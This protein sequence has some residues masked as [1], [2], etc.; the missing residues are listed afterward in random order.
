MRL[1]PSSPDYVSRVTLAVLAAAAPLSRARAQSDHFAPLVLLLPASTRAAAFGDAYVAGRDNDVIFYNPAQLGIARGVGA[2]VARYRSASTLGSLSASTALGS[3]GVGVGVQMLDYGSWP[4]VYPATAGALTSRGPLV[5]S[6]LAATLG[7]AT[8]FRDTRI[9]VAGKYVE[10]RIAG[11]RGGVL[12]ADIGLARDIGQVTVGF[13][14]QN[15][16][17]AIKTGGHRASLPQRYTFGVGGGGLPVGPFDVAASTSVAVLR[18]GFVTPAGGVEVSYSWLD[19][20]AVAARFGVRRVETNAQSPL[21]LG[22]GA[23]VDRI[24]LDYAYERY[25]GAGVAHRVG[26]R[27]RAQ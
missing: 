6:S 9:G 19:G 23:S 13:A 3:G 17:G 18:N 11:A 5:S 1:P 8:V 24:W 16:G 21:T 7:A 20:Y 14:A 4:T 27:I 25:P 26:L 2:S 22:A 10:E 15:L 12:A